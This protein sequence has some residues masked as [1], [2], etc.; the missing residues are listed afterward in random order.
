M[1]GGK[2]KEEGTHGRKIHAHFIKKK[3]TCPRPKA[4]LARLK[5]V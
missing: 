3:Q 4:L 2:L 1:G 5:C